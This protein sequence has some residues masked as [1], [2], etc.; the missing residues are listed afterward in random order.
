MTEKEETGIYFLDHQILSLGEIPEAEE[1]DS[2][3]ITELLDP[4]KKIEK[5]I[6]VV[7]FIDGD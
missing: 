4:G 2:R 6:E 7:L 3:L 5:I 1:A